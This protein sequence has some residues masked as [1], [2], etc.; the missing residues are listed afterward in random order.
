MSDT[1]TTDCQSNHIVTIEDAIALYKSRSAETESY[2]ELISLLINAGISHP[3]RNSSYFHALVLTEEMLAHT[4]HNI[5]ILT[6]NACGR[7][8]AT[9]IDHL[10][11]TLQRISE[12]GGSAK[13]IVCAEECPRWLYKLSQEFSGTFEIALGDINAKMP[14]F[15]VCDSQIVRC[16]EPHGELGSDTDANHVKAEVIFDARDKGTELEQSFDSL[17]ETANKNCAANFRKTSA[18]SWLIQR[19]EASRQRP[20]P[21]SA[22]VR[23]QFQAVEAARQR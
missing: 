22:I 4:N 20:S 12:Q 10:T 14:H 3:F 6:G 5:R 19:M 15:I 7:F 11:A 16:E 17:W 23:R 21:T 13:M 1:Q 2:R 8:Y 18:P 9:L